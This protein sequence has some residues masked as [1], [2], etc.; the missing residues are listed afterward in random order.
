MNVHLQVYAELD[1]QLGAV[2]AEWHHVALA[3]WRRLQE[4]DPEL[5][6]VAIDFFE[7]EEKAAHWFARA[8]AGATCYAR[9][10]LGNR[11]DVRNQ[12]TAAAHGMF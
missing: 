6:K 4:I 2:A 3:A 7:S 10:A 8:H 12:I 9:L 5:A 11:E 1:A